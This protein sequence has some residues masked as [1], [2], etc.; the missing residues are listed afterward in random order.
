MR[1]CWR[2][3]EFPHLPD[4]VLAVISQSIKGNHGSN[5]TARD[6]A[7][8]CLMKI[9]LSGWFDCLSMLQRRAEPAGCKPVPVRALVWERIGANTGYFGN[10][11]LMKSVKNFAAC[12]D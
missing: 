2:C 12:S 8:Y 4:N 5:Q 9:S 1:E 6:A 7:S 3:P 11:T 10:M